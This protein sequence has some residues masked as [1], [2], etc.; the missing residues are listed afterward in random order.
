MEPA[1]K[2]MLWKHLLIIGG[3]ALITIVI[4]FMS[5]L[6]CG[7]GQGQCGPNPIFLILIPIAAMGPSLA[8][9]NCLLN[10]KAE[11]KNRE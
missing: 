7:A 8:K 3:L 4:A 6:P 1:S 9:I 11:D 2:R 10:K 5:L